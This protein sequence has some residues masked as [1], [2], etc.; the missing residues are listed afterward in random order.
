M[1]ELEAPEP[2][3]QQPSGVVKAGRGRGESNQKHSK[4]ALE[5]KK[6]QEEDEEGKVVGTGKWLHKCCHSTVGYNF[7]PRVWVM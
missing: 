7:A 2:I 3:L 1:S 6:K 5:R 4:G